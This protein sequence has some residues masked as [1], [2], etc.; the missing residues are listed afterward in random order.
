[1]AP[2]LLRTSLGSRR[3]RVS[4]GACVVVQV[5][6]LGVVVRVP[7]VVVRVPVLGG[8][9]VMRVSV[10]RRGLRFRCFFKHGNSLVNPC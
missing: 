3:G 10:G 7:V 1:M 5:P 4:V 8:V 6:M 2:F 9:F